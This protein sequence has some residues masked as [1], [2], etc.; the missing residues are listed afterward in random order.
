MQISEIIGDKGKFE[1]LPMLSSKEIMLFPKA[2][3]G[4]ELQLSLISN[5]GVIQDVKLIVKDVEPQNYE[6]KIPLPH[7]YL[8][9]EENKLHEETFLQK[10]LSDQVQL[11]PY[12][13]VVRYSNNNIVLEK[14]GYFSE[15]GFRFYLINI[16]NNTGKLYKISETQLKQDFPKIE[17]DELIYSP[18]SVLG[19]RSKIQILV[20]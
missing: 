8:N 5:T 15:L 9:I 18:V 11:E 14:I 1:V 3:I 6:I 12:T 19:K 2:K 17:F 10:V 4:E 20:N 7:K 13:K 16:K